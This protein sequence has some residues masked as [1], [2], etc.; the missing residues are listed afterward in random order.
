MTGAP[1]AGPQ[2]VVGSVFAPPDDP[3]PR[4]LV[5]RHWPKGVVRGAV[6]QWEP[7]LGPRPEIADA[8]AA[9]TMTR[10]AFE[11]AYRAQVA[12]RPSLVDWA[13]RM[14]TNTGVVLLCEAHEDAACHCTLLAAILRER[15]GA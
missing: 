2:I 7:N 6:D 5:T 3:L 15:L 13:A 4:L 1:V 14:A 11:D 8:L 12:E 9:G 10:A